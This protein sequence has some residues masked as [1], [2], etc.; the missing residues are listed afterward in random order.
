VP[1]ADRDIGAAL[2]RKGV[3]INERV[4]AVD[5]TLRGAVSQK[6][7]CFDAAAWYESAQARPLG[8]PPNAPS[9]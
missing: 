2:P 5:V 1:V 6:A 8:D 3:T 7:R 9:K 4:R